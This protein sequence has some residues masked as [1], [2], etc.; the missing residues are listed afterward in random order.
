MI[1][2]AERLTASRRRISI[3]IQEAWSNLQPSELGR[4]DGMGRRF[5]FRLWMLFYL[6]A[7]T[8]LAVVVYRAAKLEYRAYR[9]ALDSPGFDSPEYQ[10]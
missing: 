7:W 2:S 1:A 9:L 4:I 10:P 8:A 6:M 3:V 5:Q